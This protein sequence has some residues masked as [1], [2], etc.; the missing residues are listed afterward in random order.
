MKTPLILLGFLVSVSVSAQHLNEK[1]LYVNEDGTV[2][3]GSVISEDRSGRKDLAVANG[4]LQGTA[5]Y[6]NVSGTLIESGTFDKGLKHGKWTRYFEN[7]LVSAIGFYSLGN[8]S[9]TWLVFDESGKKRFEFSYQNGLKSGT[10]TN[11]D[12]NG[13]IVSV[14]DYSQAN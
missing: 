12:E 13:A 1:G 8:K 5:L 3:N 9:G 2:F 14:K 11:W 7:G 10:W 4:M 6:Y